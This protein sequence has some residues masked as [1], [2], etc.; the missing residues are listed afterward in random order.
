MT[1]VE[2]LLKSGESDDNMLLFYCFQRDLDISGIFDEDKR[3]SSYNRTG[4]AKLD[5]TYDF[6]GPIN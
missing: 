4:T 5:D 1:N 6:N 2:N 3:Y